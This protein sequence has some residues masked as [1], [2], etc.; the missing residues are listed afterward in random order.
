MAESLEQKTRGDWREAM[1]CGIGYLFFEINESSGRY[2]SHII[3]PV[4]K[5]IGKYV[6]YQVF[7]LGAAAFSIELFTKFK[8]YF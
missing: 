7:T 1:P 3:N 2:D 6:A 4:S 5:N 8:D